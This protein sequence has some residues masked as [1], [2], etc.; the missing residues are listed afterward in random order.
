MRVAGV[1]DTRNAPPPDHKRRSDE[2]ENQ[3]FGGDD[4]NHLCCIRNA[5]NRQWGMSIPAGLL[6]PEKQSFGMHKFG[7][8]GNIWHM[9]IF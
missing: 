3:I 4:Q 9:A 7:D 8:T 6:L 2:L 5:D 1:D